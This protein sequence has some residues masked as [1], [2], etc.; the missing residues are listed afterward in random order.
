MNSILSWLITVVNDLFNCKG[1]TSDNFVKGVPLDLGSRVV[2][3]RVWYLFAVAKF[4]IWKRRCSF[5][6]ERKQISVQKVILQIKG[7]VSDRI[8]IDFQR[9]SGSKFK[10]I[11]VD[12]SLLCSVSNDIVQCNLF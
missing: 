12:G 11:W 2:W 6:F 1:F 7:E 8:R 9:W 3:G 10:K 5:V 4:Q